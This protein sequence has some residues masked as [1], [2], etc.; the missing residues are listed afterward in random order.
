MSRVF[1]TPTSTRILGS[2]GY[3]RVRRPLLVLHESQ[4]PIEK[5]KNASQ[6]PRSQAP[7]LRLPLPPSLSRLGLGALAGHHVELVELE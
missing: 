3:Q 4:S 6:Q 2:S 7:P 5:P 1:E